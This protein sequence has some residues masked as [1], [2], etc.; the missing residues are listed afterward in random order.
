MKVKG[1]WR[2]LITTVS[3]CSSRCY[4]LMGKGKT[5]FLC[6]DLAKVGR[7]EVM[8]KGDVQKQI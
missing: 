5:L 1:N 7:R 2:I 4:F 8:L 3:V 6:S